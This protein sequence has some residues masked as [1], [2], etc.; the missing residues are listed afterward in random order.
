MGGAFVLI[1]SSCEVNGHVGS[2]LS[3][4]CPCRGK[5]IVTSL[6]QIFWIT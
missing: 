5:I 2:L 4:P 6:D 3:L 1:A